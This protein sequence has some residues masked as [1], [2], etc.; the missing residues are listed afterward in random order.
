MRILVNAL[1]TVWLIP[2]C[3]R[4]CENLFDKHKSYFGC[5]QEEWYEAELKTQDRVEWH[6]IICGICRSCSHINNAK[7]IPRPKSRPR[8]MVRKLELKDKHAN[9]ADFKT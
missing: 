6:R 4:S 2:V 7:H 5:S 3:A 8:P 9:C 1:F